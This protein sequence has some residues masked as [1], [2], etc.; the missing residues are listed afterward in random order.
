MPS[1]FSSPFFSSYPPSSLLSSFLLPSLKVDDL[2]SVMH[3]LVPDYLGA[4]LEH[5]TT[6]FILCI[7]SHALSFMTDLYHFMSAVFHPFPS[8]LCPVSDIWCPVSDIWCPVSEIWCPVS[9]I[10]CSASFYIV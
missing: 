4:L 8:C 5:Q 1:L 3:F 2:W 6:P 10:W 9:D 7:V